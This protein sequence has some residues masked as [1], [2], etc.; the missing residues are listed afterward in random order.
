MK[1]NRKII[2]TLLFLLPIIPYVISIKSYK[3]NI[4]LKDLNTFISDKIYNQGE[5]KKKFP[6]KKNENYYLNYSIN[7]KLSN[8]VKKRLKYYRPDLAAIVIIESK[9]GKILTSIGYNREINNFNYYLPYTGTHPA[10]SIFKIVTSAGLFERSK[11]DEKEKFLFRGKSTT[12]YRYQLTNKKTRG[13]RESSLSNAFARSNN[14]IFGKAAIQNISP[15]DLFQT[16]SL[17]GFNQSLMQELNL[18]KSTFITPKEGQD[19]AEAASGFNRTTSISPVHCALLSSAVHMEGNFIYPR[20]ITSVRDEQKK[21]IWENKTKSK[22]IFNKKTAQQLEK[23]MIQTIKKGTA[24]KKFRNIKK[25]LKK[26]L[27]IGGKTGTITGGLPYGKRDWFTS[28]SYPV[29]NKD[30]GISIC[31]MNINFKKWYVK[32]T[33]ISKEIIQYYYS[34]IQKI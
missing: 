7:K 10:A 12:L 11:I 21:I 23:M 17:L 34:H 33:Q 18:S 2:L 26:K 32:S 9:T 31:T 27:I 28:F 4:F 1:I 24:R 30:L 8:F 5:L 14:V 29:N 3:K 6:R 20:L 19:L 15:E 25:S 22:K 13:T 16:A